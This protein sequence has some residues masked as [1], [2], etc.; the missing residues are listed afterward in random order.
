MN[1]FNKKTVAILV[2]TVSGLIVSII[3]LSMQTNKK[4]DYFNYKLIT[5]NT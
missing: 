1:I 3:F 4:F 5:L 2:G